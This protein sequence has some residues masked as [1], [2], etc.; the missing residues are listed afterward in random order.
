MKSERLF[1]ILGLVDEDLIDAAEVPAPRRRQGWKPIAAIAACLVLVLGIGWGAGFLRTGKNSSDATGGGGG[2]D[3]GTVFMSYGGP[4][5]PLTAEEAA[6]GVTAER[7]I[8]WDFTPTAYA[9]GSPRQWGAAVTDGYVLSNGTEEDVTL[10]ALYPFTGSLRDLESLTPEIAV[11]GGTVR[12][13]L[14]AGAY[15]GGFTHGGGDP[16]ETLN[17]EQLN[18]W[19]QYKDLLSGGAYQDRALAPYAET[20]ISVVVY[21][22]SDF[23][24]PHEEYPAATQAAAFDMD[25]AETTILTYG[26]NGGE[27]REGWRR[28]SYFV[29]NGVQREKD[30]KLLIFIG[31]EPESYTL[32]GYQDGGCDEGEEIDGVSCSVTRRETTLDE[33]LYEICQYDRTRYSG[34]DD[35]P[36]DYL[37]RGAMELLMDSGPLASGGSADRY[38]T[39][40]LDEVISD[41]L[42][43]TRVMYLRFD[44]TIPAGGTAE[45]SARLWKQPSHDF[46]CSGSENVGIQGYDMVTRLG[47][48]LDFTRQTAAL[49][50]AEALEIV[51]QSFGFDPEAGIFEVELDM[52][53]EHYYLELRVRK[54]E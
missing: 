22:F 33:I 5:L 20:G 16:E 19:E 18:S 21:E 36:V 10:S 1:R 49:V 13:E 54:E 7:N 14:L 39:G 47:S 3:A 28:F 31:Q 8:T 2:H 12:P 32:Q 15:P 38:D 9:D 48:V 6:E 41:A 25:E 50:N 51:R 52:D 24:A 30:W 53:Q 44:V 42:A 45:V 17:L 11:D 43:V 4:V 26:F 35:I 23:A 27:Y 37:F 34:E 29:P 40:M 46:Y